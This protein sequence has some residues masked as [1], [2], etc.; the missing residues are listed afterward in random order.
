MAAF[1]QVETTRHQVALAG[2]VSDAQSGKPIPGARVTLSGGPP[3]FAER[4]ALWAL[5]HGSVPG[6]GRP[7][8]ACSAA[9]GHYYFLDLPDGGY[10][11][12]ASLPAEGSRYAVAHARF[13]VSSQPDGRVSM[14]W[15]HLALQPTVVRGKVVASKNGATEPIAMA[16]VRVK[17]SG[18]GA[19]TDAKGRYELAGVEAGN[20]IIVVTARGYARIERGVALGEAGAEQTLDVT[21]NKSA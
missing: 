14:A 8:H 4:L 9:D 7:D 19:L 21:L 12:A 11:V 3:A 15:V 17:G 13:E 10:D 2:T 6:P 16:S 5:Q 18:E 1:M 20:R